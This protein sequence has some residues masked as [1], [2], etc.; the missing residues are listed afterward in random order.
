M[1]Y[2]YYGMC[3]LGHGALLCTT[4]TIVH[5]KEP[6][7]F[8]WPCAE[9]CAPSQNSTSPFHLSCQAGS[10][11]GGLEAQRPC[12]AAQGAQ[13]Q[14]QPLEN[15]MSESLSG[16]TPCCK[17]R[18][19]KPTLVLSIAALMSLTWYYWWYIRVHTM[20]YQVYISGLRR[21]TKYMK[22]AKCTSGAMRPQTINGR[23]SHSIFVRSLVIMTF[24]LHSL[25]TCRARNTVSRPAWAG[26]AIPSLDHPSHCLGSNHSNTVSGP[27][28][29]ATRSR[30]LLGAQHCLETYRARSTVSSV[31]RPSKSLTRRSSESLTRT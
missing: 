4:C 14:P 5:R 11:A 19:W 26:H 27:A 17:P 25:E 13:R 23:V 18:R 10:A 16:D 30:D 12:R 28:G 2:L 22:N 31:S 24:F 9:C 15:G 8:P 3:T 20:M 29:R 21:C 6:Q 1:L 7:W